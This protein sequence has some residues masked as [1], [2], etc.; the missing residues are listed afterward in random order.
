MKKLSVAQVYRAGRTARTWN[1]ETSKVQL[2]SEARFMLRFS[3]SSK[4]GGITEVKVTIGSEDFASL[5][6][7]MIAADRGRAMVDMSAALAVQVANQSE[8][9][10]A[11]I[12][13]ARQSVVSAAEKAFSEAP[14]GRDHAERLTR[15]VVRQLVEEL[16]SAKPEQPSGT[17]DAA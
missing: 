3:L 16:N 14:S 17:T 1:F 12:R 11:T 10:G 8:H 5:L 13:D 9:D 4:G 2:S 15:D 7:A 6:Q